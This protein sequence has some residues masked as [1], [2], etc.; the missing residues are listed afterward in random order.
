MLRDVLVV[1]GDD[2]TRSGEVEHVVEL[3]VPP[4][5]RGRDDECGGGDLVLGQDGQLDPELD[6][7]SL[8]HAGQLA[9]T[10]DADDGEASGGAF[11]LGH[12]APA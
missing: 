10:H 9:T 5:R 2:V 11:R 7:G 6:R 3:G 1:E 8:H 12:G 4:D